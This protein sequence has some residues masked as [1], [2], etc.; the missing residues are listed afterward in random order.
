MADWP[1]YG[2]L[3]MCQESVEER[4]LSSGPQILQSGKLVGFAGLKILG[5]AAFCLGQKAAGGGR[6]VFGQTSPKLNR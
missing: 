4:G 1:L 3:H 2:H 6:V 5:A